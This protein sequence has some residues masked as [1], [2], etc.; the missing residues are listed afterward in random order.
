MIAITTYVCNV[1]ME[2]VENTFVKLKYAHVFKNK[3]IYII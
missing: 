3:K 1:C 2:I